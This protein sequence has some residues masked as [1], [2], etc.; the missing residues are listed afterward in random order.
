M[1]LF[2]AHLT[3]QDGTVNAKASARVARTVLDILKNAKKVIS[4]KRHDNYFLTKKVGSIKITSYSLT[5]H[6]IHIFV[7]SYLY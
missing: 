3:G 6:L 2:N 4:P 5:M 7:D 1:T